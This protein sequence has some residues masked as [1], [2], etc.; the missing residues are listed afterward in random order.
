MKRLPLMY[1]DA[2]DWFVL[3]TPPEHYTEEAAWVLERIPEAKSLLELGS[4][5]GHLASHLGGVEEVVLSDLS[6]QMLE[7]SK[8]LNPAREHVE[9]DMRTL[10]LGRDFD[11]VLIHD[12][13]GYM[14]TEQDLDAAFETAAAHLEPGGKV[15]VM[16]D[17]VAEKFAD[18][19][20][21]GGSDHEDGRGMR[22]LEWQF[23][24]QDEDA[25][26]YD[27]HYSLMLRSADGSVEVIH[28]HHRIGLFPC[29]TW[30][31]R[32]EAAGFE[33]EQEVDD[34]DREVFIGTR[35]P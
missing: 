1:T 8:R 21:H 26:H 7:S 27:V 33:V 14:L 10:R 23:R 34:W 20:N 12:A 15:I 29:K 28:D 30:I 24:S 19:T 11:A 6:P 16:P 35:K 5:G 13:I 25:T 22:Y 31:A 9:G 18:D 17:V 32:L 3:L 4:G 2:A